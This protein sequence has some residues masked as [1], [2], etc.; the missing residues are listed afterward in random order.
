LLRAEKKI[1][2]FA[3]PQYSTDDS[4]K[5]YESAADQI[6]DVHIVECSGHSFSMQKSFN[7]FLDD[8]KA[9]YEQAKQKRLVSRRQKQRLMFIFLAKVRVFLL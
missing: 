9:E 8:V 7:H 4:T 2:E 6:V 5:R 3:L 1:L